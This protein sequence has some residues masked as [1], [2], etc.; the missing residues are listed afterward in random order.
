MMVKF[1]I[2]NAD[3][4]F[5]Q[6]GVLI[7]NV[8]KSHATNFITFSFAVKVVMVVLRVWG[9]LTKIIGEHMYV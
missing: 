6:I 1:S 4:C 8:F 3:Q 2:R 9:I 7:K 5:Q